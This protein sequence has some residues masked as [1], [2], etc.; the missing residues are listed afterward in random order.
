MSIGNTYIPSFNLYLQSDTADVINTDAD[1]IFY[2]KN[3]ITIPAGVRCLI[4]LIDFELPYSFY[5]INEYN[6]KLNISTST[7]TLNITISPSNYDSDTIVNYLNTVFSTNASILGTT[8]VMTVSYST[9]KFT[10]ISDTLD[11]T[12]LDTTTCGFELGL[13]NLPLSST[14]QSITSPNCMN[15]AGTPYVE[16]YT[17]FAITQLSSVTDKDGTLI[18]IPVRTE[19]SDY[20]FYQSTQNIYHMIADRNIDKVEVRLLDYKGNLLNLNGAVFSM[21][22]NFEFQ[23]QR[24]PQLTNEFELKDAYKNLFLKNE[25]QQNK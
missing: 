7:G 1:C 10:F 23:Y 21:T 2:L 20:I 4:S 25:N 6:N 12:I 17:N 3:K 22:L 11:F 16:I 24:V 19:P 5:N 14:S 15:L 18:R 8:I 13:G 9:N